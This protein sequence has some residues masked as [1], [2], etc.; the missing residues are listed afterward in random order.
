MSQ[1]VPEDLFSLA[2]AP[3]DHGAAELG[4]EAAAAEG[5]LP[6]GV[7]SIARIARFVVARLLRTGGPRAGVA[8][9]DFMVDE[10]D[11]DDGRLER[12]GDD[13]DGRAAGDDA[14]AE[15]AEAAEEE[16]DKVFGEAEARATDGA[17]GPSLALARCA[18]P[19][20]R[21]PDCT[22]LCSRDTPPLVHP[23]T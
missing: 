23:H 16:E 22:R 4:D 2:F 9:R 19:S 15:A 5:G 21:L 13:D 12:D 14:A 6:P 18:L 10:G 8:G 11:D 20:R 7:V 3:H 17:C 1:N